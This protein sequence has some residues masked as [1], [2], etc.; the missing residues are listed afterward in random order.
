MGFRYQENRRALSTAEDLSLLGF[1]MLLLVPVGSD[2]TK[3]M[4]SCRERQTETGRQTEEQREERSLSQ[5]VRVSPSWS[6]SIPVRA[7][8]LR[9]QG[10]TLFANQGS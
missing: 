2:G 7:D 1:L 6:L 5:R 9:L 4:G 3:D 10:L 8:K